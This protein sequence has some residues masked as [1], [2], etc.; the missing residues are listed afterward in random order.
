MDMI[1]YYVTETNK[2]LDKIDSKID[3]L[4]EFRAGIMQQSKTRAI[5]ISAIISLAI[6]GIAAFLRSL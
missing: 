3:K 2:R 6:S 1:E 5:V 4:M